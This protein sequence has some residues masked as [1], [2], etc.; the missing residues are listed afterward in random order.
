[1]LNSDAERLSLALAAARLG[2]WSWNAKTD[3]VDMSP[4]AAEIFGI[5]PGPHMTWARMR[6]LLHADDAERAR[7]AVERAIE[8]RTDYGIEYRVVHNGAERWVAASGRGVY[9]GDEVVGMLGVIQDITEQVRTRER[10]QLEAESLETINRVG[11]LLSGQ[12]DLQPLV[13][14][15]TDAATELSGAEFGAFFYNVLDDKGESYMLYTLSGVPAEAFSKFPMPRSTAVFAPTFRGEAV[16]RLDDVR[17]DSRF[18]RNAPHYGMPKGHLPVVSY[19]AVPV[20]GRAGEVIGGLFFGHSQPG[21]FDERAERIVTG[22]AGQAAIAI[23]NARL[24]EAAQ[25]ARRASEDAHARMTAV[26]DAIPDIFTA[27]DAEGRYTYA[28]AAARRVWRQQGR[29]LDV[30][31]RKRS[32]VFPELKDSEFEHLFNKVLQTRQPLTVETYF[33]P[34]HKWFEVGY[35][36]MPDGGVCTVSHDITDKKRAAELVQRSEARFREVASTNSALT[37][38][39]QDCDL[40]YTWVFPR[41][42]EH[43]SDNIGKTDEDL[44]P[45]SEG[46]RLSAVKRAAIESGVGGRHEIS[47]TLP[48]G[49]HTYDLV[50][51]PRRDANGTIVGVGG[52]AVDITD[53]KRNELLLERAEQA[54][55]ESESRLRDADRRKDEFL[56]MLAHELRNPLAPIRTGLH[57]LGAEESPQ[58]VARVRAMMERQVGHIVRLVDDLLDVSRITSGKIHLRREAVAIPEL[59]DQAIESNRAGIA[60]RDI[61][62]LTHVDTGSTAV[63]VD[64]TRMVQVIANVLNNAVKFSPARGRITVGSTVDGDA[65]VITIADEGAG[66]LPDMLPQIFELFVQGDAPVGGSQGGLGI[67]LALARTLVEMHG[68][69]IEA[70]SAG[71]GQ[72]STFTIRVPGV[73]MTTPVAEAPVHK[74]VTPLINRRVLVVDDNDDSAELLAVLVQRMGGEARTAR[75]GETAVS[76]AEEFSP[77]FI[78]LDIGL[79]GIDGYE[80][81]RQIRQRH[82]SR[83]MIVALT[84]WG[85]DQDK[86]RALEAG[87]DLHLTKP[88]DPVALESLLANGASNARLSSTI[89]G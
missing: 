68:G 52:V 2:D 20:I 62:L 72:G 85:Q 35:F 17:K 25:R 49:V 84:G 50:V 16:I 63:L 22:L 9:A 81:C 44:L 83:P 15:V 59:I 24:F 65:A 56:A 58:A 46:A 10:L 73:V 82:G 79:P 87:F 13:Q 43:F 54:T 29:S 57:L 1:M 76:A 34:F 39:E 45:P 55:R 86:R 78:L 74:A 48:G 28:N 18:G 7:I 61:T 5:P 80:A 30:I 53:R 26:L 88:V 64:P 6:S 67:G 21:I 41:H 14:S 51:E 70:T 71:R 38:Y 27:A 60:A 32:E 11:R 77:D 33:E 36:P 42:P 23:D 89:D 19:L 8:T 4:R 75:D 31:G 69:R 47:V 12:L 3:L 40:K 66:I 37:L